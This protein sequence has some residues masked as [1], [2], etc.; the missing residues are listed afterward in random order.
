MQVLVALNAVTNAN[1]L[2]FILPQQLVLEPGDVIG[3]Y[4]AT[5]SQMFPLTVSD[6]GSPTLSLI[7]SNILNF[8]ART[9]TALLSNPLVTFTS[10]SVQLIFEVF[11]CMKFA[12][13]EF[14]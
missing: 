11:G 10:S 5:T 14:A 1:L 12:C 13:T 8:G 4:R 3:I 2:E 6:T 7:S 9:A